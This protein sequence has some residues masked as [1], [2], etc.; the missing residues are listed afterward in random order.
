[1]TKQLLV[2]IALGKTNKTKRDKRKNIDEKIGRERLPIRSWTFCYLVSVSFLFVP[3]LLTKSTIT[4]DEILVKPDAALLVFSTLCALLIEAIEKR[5][6]NI[7]LFDAILTIFSIVS[8]CGMVT[9]PESFFSVHST[10]INFILLLGC[11]I[12]GL[13]CYSK[14]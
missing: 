12:S 13:I 2:D 8:Y 7:L 11:F 1:M 4:Q 10:L 3:I 5:K 14:R 9:A 6:E